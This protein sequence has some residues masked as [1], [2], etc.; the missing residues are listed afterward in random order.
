MYF[1]MTRPDRDFHEV[2]ALDDVIGYWVEHEQDRIDLIAHYL[3]LV[4]GQ[5]MT[6]QIRDRMYHR[7]LI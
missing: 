3:S 6:T 1:M 2:G 7:I 4:G 5:N